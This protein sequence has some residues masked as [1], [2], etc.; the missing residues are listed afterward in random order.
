MLNGKS[1][2]DITLTGPGAVDLPVRSFSE[3]GIK[4]SG[5]NIGGVGV[6]SMSVHL[7]F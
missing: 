2:Q 3:T 5:F 7:Y 6:T 1:T 4:G